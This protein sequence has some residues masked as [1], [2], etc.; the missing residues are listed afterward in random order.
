MQRP[1]PG[2]GDVAVGGAKTVESPP[3]KGAA[4]NLDVH[5]LVRRGRRVQAV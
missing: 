1:K 5:D 3:G 4:A 2:G